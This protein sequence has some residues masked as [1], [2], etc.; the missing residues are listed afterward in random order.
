MSGARKLKG[1]ILILS[2]RRA[3]AGGLLL[4]FAFALLSWRGAA[5]EPKLPFSSGEKMR[6][7]VRWRLVP[8][9]EA[10][11]TLGKEEGAAGRWK[12]TAKANSIGYVSNIYKVEDEYQ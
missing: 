2:K 6:Y 9:G 7:A 8:A 10:E 12:A 3:A 4:I 11:L 1:I 5:Q